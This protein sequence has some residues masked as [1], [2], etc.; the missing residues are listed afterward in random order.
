[1]AEQLGKVDGLYQACVAG[2]MLK[3]YDSLAAIGDRVG[4]N[5]SSCASI[6]SW[7]VGLSSATRIRQGPPTPV[8]ALY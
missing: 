6:T 5:F 7:L 2:S 4:F 8:F 3:S 1:M